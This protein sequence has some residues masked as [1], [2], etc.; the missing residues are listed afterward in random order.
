[1][2]AT[3]PNHLSSIKFS[4]QRAVSIRLDQVVAVRKG[5]LNTEENKATFDPVFNSQLS[6]PNPVLNPV[7]DTLKKSVN[8]LRKS[9]CI[10]MAEKSASYQMAEISERLTEN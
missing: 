2:V 4:G 7:L 10:A 3:R 9:P 5:A 8:Q 1:M 6:V